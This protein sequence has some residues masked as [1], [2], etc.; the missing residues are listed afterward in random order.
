M[1]LRRERPDRLITLILTFL[2]A[3]AFW[4]PA[5]SADLEE[6]Q[7]K[8]LYMYNFAKFVQW[9]EGSFSGPEDTINL[10]VIG[11]DPFDRLLEEA[12]ERTA[13]GRSFRITR[14]RKW[15]DVPADCHMLFVGRM[16]KKFMTRILDSVAGRPVL[17]VGDENS[18]S[19]AGGIIALVT[20]E[21]RIR[22]Q[23]S[24]QALIESNLKLSS[25]LLRLA[26]IID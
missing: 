24:R 17:T 12:F 26:E 25:N 20:R 11:Q 1:R 13:Q 19:R 22:F 21:N 23:V 2:F 18:F 5:W 10:Y 3:A 16:E 14:M 7:V 15:E 9:P 8:A 4:V 6:Y